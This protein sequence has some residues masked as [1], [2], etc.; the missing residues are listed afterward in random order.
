MCGCVCNACVCV[1]IHMYIDIH[2][3]ACTRLYIYIY[4]Y[5]Y[6]WLYLRTGSWVFAMATQSVIDARFHY[7]FMQRCAKHPRLW[8]LM[9]LM[10]F[11]IL[12]RDAIGF[13][14]VLVNILIDMQLEFLRDMQLGSAGVHGAGGV[15]GFLIKRCNGICH[16]AST[17]IF[18]IYC[19]LSRWLYYLPR[20]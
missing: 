11:V 18:H 14:R 5:I 7:L 19:E 8:K 13:L 17:S 12:N 10:E 20:C 2:V 3:F 4:I 9:E 15:H 6:I 16:G 1:Y